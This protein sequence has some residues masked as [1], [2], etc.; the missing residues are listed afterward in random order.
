LKLQIQET[1]YL[2]CRDKKILH[3]C[4]YAGYA[5]NIKNL[6]VLKDFKPIDHDDISVII[7]KEYIDEFINYE[8]KTKNKKIYIIP[9]N[10]YY[11]YLIIKEKITKLKQIGYEVSVITYEEWFEYDVNH[12]SFNRM[13]ISKK[14]TLKKIY[15][16]NFKLKLRYYFPLIQSIYNTLINI[17]FSLPL[18]L[19]SKIVYVGRASVKETIE[20]FDNLLNKRVITKHLHEK[21]LKNLDHSKQ[22]ELFELI[23]DDEFKNLNFI[24]HYY[25]YNVIIRFLIISHLNKFKNFY[26]K[27]DKL[28]NLQLLNTNVYKKIFHID[29]G[30]KCGNSFV[31]DRTIYLEKFFKKKYLRF[32]LFD[33]D[34]NYNSSNHF[35]NRL[36]K[37]DNFLKMVYENKNFNSSFDELKKWLVNINTDLTN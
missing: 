28:F 2:R 32:N 3:Y 4:L 10:G 31:G 14:N 7:E 24:W 18:L 15:G 12:Y 13:A 26:H 6:I 34:I 21:I 22:K 37:I 29:F 8:F 11:D 35:K 19:R 33:K 9:S 20:S 17:R 30:V 36:L 23:D 27:T 25:I 16:A 1:V 5:L